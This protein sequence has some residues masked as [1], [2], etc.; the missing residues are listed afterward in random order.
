MRPYFA[1]QC[2]LVFLLMSLLTSGYSLRVRRRS[3]SEKMARKLIYFLNLDKIS[4]GSSFENEQAQAEMLAKNS[5]AKDP[6]LEGCETPEQI[7][8]YFFKVYSN[9]SSKFDSKEL[10]QIILHQVT[11]DPKEGDLNEKTKIHKCK[12]KTV[13]EFLEASL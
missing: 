3:L 1:T 7:R 6:L 11:G 8:D 10:D 2:L 9:D 4:I 12:R 5:I 13:S